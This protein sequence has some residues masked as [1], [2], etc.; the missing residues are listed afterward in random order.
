MSNPLA[1]LWRHPRR[2]GFIVLNIVVLAAFA[3][4]G[5]YT[6]NAADYGVGALPAIMLGYTGMALLAVVWVA[7]W[8]AWAWLVASRRLNRNP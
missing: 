4:W 3:A 6:A 1:Y 5:I 7:A 8:I 2:T